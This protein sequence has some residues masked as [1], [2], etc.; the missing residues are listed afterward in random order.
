MCVS[1]RKEKKEVF[2]QI[3]CDLLTKSYKYDYNF[4]STLQKSL[5][6]LCQNEKEKIDFSMKEIAFKSNTYDYAIV[7]TE[8]NQI[9]MMMNP[10]LSDQP[11]WQRK[12]KEIW[13]D[14]VDLYHHINE[15]DLIYGVL[16]KLAEGEEKK[17][18]LEALN[19]KK[20]GSIKDSE[21]LLDK[22]LS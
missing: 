3:I 5:I 8:E 19:L 2:K 21:K 12:V 18:L 22:A 16:L 7:F 1:A 6:C 4:I 14:L 20:I 15:E 17:V 10:D 11:A 9:Q 13:G